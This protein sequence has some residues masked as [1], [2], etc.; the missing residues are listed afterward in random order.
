M[1]ALVTGGRFDMWQF[2][3]P[4]LG[5]LL[6]NSSNNRAT[7]SAVNAQNQGTMA[8][9]AM[10]Q[11]QYDL[12]RKDNEPFIQ[13]AQ[14]S[15]KILRGFLGLDGEEA[16]QQAFSNY[17]Q[18]P[19]VNFLQE[20]GNQ[21]IIRNASAT[22]G[23]GGGNVL[24][25]L[26]S[27]GT[28]VAESSLGDHLNRLAAAQGSGQTAAS[29]M[30]LMGQQYASSVAGANSQM[31]QNTASGIMSRNQNDQN[32]FSQLARMGMGAAAGSGLYGN[33]YQR[34]YGGNPRAGFLTGAY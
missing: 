13:S 20:Q 26:Q 30:G 16:Q 21:N 4:V 1:S 14:D 12:A 2:I 34:F 9:L 7:E 8:G 17:Q 11:Q 18:S 27:Y 25:S 6:G 31:G 29:Q 15:N 33:Q 28:S 19:H 24:K 22:G 5:S 32:T 3:V 10:Q 23:L